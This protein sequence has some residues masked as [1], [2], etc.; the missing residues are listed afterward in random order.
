MKIG[1]GGL[2]LLCI[3][4]VV[5]MLMMG[6]P[7]V[8]RPP[9]VDAWKPIP[10][11]TEA[12]LLSLPLFRGAKVIADGVSWR[13]KYALNHCEIEIDATG[14]APHK[15]RMVRLIARHDGQGDDTA[16]RQALIDLAGLPYA[17]AEPARARQWVTDHMDDSDSIVIAGVRFE[18]SEAGRVRLLTLSA[19]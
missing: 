9:V 19:E 5:I 7:K 17:G 13:A 4:G 2:L 14:R 8:D 18:I 6:P 3:I 16:A 15:V 1:C 11:L 10:G 12:Q